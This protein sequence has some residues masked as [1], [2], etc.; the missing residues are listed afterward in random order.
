LAIA[1]F[2]L[3][4]HSVTI[5]SKETVS[6]IIVA[7]GASKRMDGL[8]KVFTLLGGRPVL[9]WVVNVFQKCPLVHRIVI[10]VGQQNIDATK[11]M[12][13]E[14]LWTKV[15]AVCAGGERR[16][17][18]V[19]A[20][21]AQLKPCDWVIVHDCARPLVTADLIERGLEEAKETGSA[22]AAVPVTDTIKLAD[23]GMLV[24]GTPPRRSLW[25]V[26]TPQIFRYNII[27]EAYRQ[28]KYEVTD[29]STLVERAGYKVKLF[30]GA[31]DNIKITTPEDMALAEVLVKKHGR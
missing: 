20:G 7:A 24:Q 23:D 12:V 8:D 3:Y 2:L 21:L 29:D 11:E 6:A 16:Q 5:Q 14:R 22:A 30:M 4:N 18:S 17:D 19:S 1:S 9:A 10:V 28:M 15:T 25:A 26:Q 31:Y 27:T 13:N